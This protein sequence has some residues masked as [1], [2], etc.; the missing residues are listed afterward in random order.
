WRLATTFCLWRTQSKRYS[1][2]TRPSACVT[3]RRKALVSASFPNATTHQKNLRCCCRRW[4]GTRPLATAREDFAF[5]FIEQ[6]FIEHRSIIALNGNTHT[7]VI[8][9]VNDDIVVFPQ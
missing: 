5:D 2:F 8:N 6:T 4:L 1:V 3:N 9:V 7:V